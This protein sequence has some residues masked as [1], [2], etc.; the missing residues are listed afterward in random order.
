MGGVGE[1]GRPLFLQGHPLDL[2]KPPLPG[3]LQGKV[4]P[5]VPPFDLPPESRKPGEEPG[6]VFLCHLVG[7]LAVYVDQIG[8]LFHRQPGQ[9]WFCGR[10]FG[11]GPGTPW[12]RGP[13]A[14]A[15]AGIFHM[16]NLQLPC[17]L[18]LGDEPVGP[19]R[20]TASST[21]PYSTVFPLFP[22][23]GP[24]CYFWKRPAPYSRGRNSPPWTVRFWN[25][26]GFACQAS[27]V[28]NQSPRGIRLGIWS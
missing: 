7:G 19:G 10:G 24:A 14:P 11:R 8:A 21:A 23:P 20:K 28:S 22:G 3:G 13:A 1:E 17:P 25:S 9:T 16:A 2:Q 6:Q 26:W 12:P 15:A 18:H 4:E 5:G 27:P